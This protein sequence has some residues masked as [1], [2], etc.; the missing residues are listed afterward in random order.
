[1]VP[2]PPGSSEENDV[3]TRI[4]EA[5]TSLF[6]RKGY[7]STSVREI[8]QAAGVTKPALYYYFANK[9]ALFVELIN[10]HM[11]RLSELIRVSLEGDG[12]VRERLHSF[13]R[14]YVDGAVEHKDVVQLMW[15]AHHPTDDKQPLVDLMSMH[16]RKISQLIVLFEE[17]K[18]T[19]ELRPD[20]DVSYAVRAFIGTVDLH[21]M[22]CV[23]GLPKDA[24][25]AERIL[26]LTY[27][28][29][30]G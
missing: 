29:V 26:D 10:M 14:M 11:D 13:L 2:P 6:S 25:Y 24:D 9:E 15:K 27:R 12:T 16:T 4:L 28:G 1:M 18:T 7:G 19:G 21:T 30:S 3:K 17:G 8:V 5:A 23:H 22:A 20:L